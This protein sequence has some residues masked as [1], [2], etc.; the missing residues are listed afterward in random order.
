MLKLSEPIVYIEE[1]VLSEF[2]FQLIKARQYSMISILGQ[3]M[4]AVAMEG[5]SY[6]SANNFY[7]RR[8]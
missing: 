7:K 3:W 4:R 2:S 1:L 6:S 8:I 5:I